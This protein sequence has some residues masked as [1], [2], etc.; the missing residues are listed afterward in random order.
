MMRG[1]IF[2]LLR[3]EVDRKELES[4]IYDWE[5]PNPK[6]KELWIKIHRKEPISDE[7]YKWAQ[8]FFEKEKESRKS[9]TDTMLKKV[10]DYRG[11]GYEQQSE[12]VKSGITVYHDIIKSDLI[13]FL[14]DIFDPK[15]KIQIGKP[16]GEWFRANLNDL[17]EFRNSITNYLGNMVKWREG[18]MTINDKIE[19]TRKKLQDQDWYGIVENGDWSI[20]NKIDTNY[21][22]WAKDITKRQLNGDL[23]MG[24]DMK[25]IKKYFEKRDV[26]EILPKEWIDTLRKV[27]KLKKIR[28]DKISFAH[29]DFINRF[30]RDKE[31]GLTELKNNLMS[32]TLKG[33]ESE[34]HFFTLLSNRPQNFHNV[35]RYALWGNVVD[36]I[37]G[38]DGSA[39]F[40]DG[41]KLIQVKSS[42]N[43]AKKA[44]I[45]NL[46]IPYVSVYPISKKFKFTFNY[47]SENNPSEPSNFNIKYVNDKDKPETYQDKE[48]AA[49]QKILGKPSSDEYFESDK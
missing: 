45:K 9:S 3:E 26:N 43:L 24:S 14:N 48:M 47:F 11:G 15:L 29:V 23:P 38:V 34:D 39:K 6:M 18:A 31:D 44:I 20:L 28:I 17:R 21:T 8:R 7:E 42:E 37:F 16:S 5:G 35:K 13:I 2:K 46:G 49:L 12:I 10:Q 32:T 41:F 25:I 40:A 22:S 36:M 19:E 4:K 27:E 1:L 33:D 30:H